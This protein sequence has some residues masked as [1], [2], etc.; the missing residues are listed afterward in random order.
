MTG[1]IDQIHA[2]QIHTVIGLHIRIC[3]IGKFFQRKRGHLDLQ[4]IR[5]RQIQYLLAEPLFV[6]EAA[7]II[8]RIQCVFPVISDK[9]IAV[10]AVIIV[11][12]TQIDL[13]ASAAL[14]NISALIVFPVAVCQFV[15]SL[16]G[17]HL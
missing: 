14:Q 13:H 6:R 9:I 7:V 4:L 17:S 2:V 1:Q 10:V 15:I 3:Q 16:T 5:I 12:P 8:N 11:F